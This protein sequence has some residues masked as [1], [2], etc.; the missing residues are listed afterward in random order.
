ML[1]IFF[2]KYFYSY[3]YLLFQTG[4]R[5]WGYICIRFFFFLPES[6]NSSYRQVLFYT[7]DFY[8]QGFR[9][10][11]VGM[12]P[13]Q[14]FSIVHSALVDGDYSLR[15]PFCPGPSKDIREISAYKGKDIERKY[16]F[17]LS[18]EKLETLPSFP[19]LLLTSISL[20][21]TNLSLQSV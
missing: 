15:R 14:S 7:W 6:C 9:P 20:P 10:K 1:K 12:I 11:K 4:V 5:L 17:F 18:I 16:L 2:F 13:V 3:T 19:P 8:P 21:Q